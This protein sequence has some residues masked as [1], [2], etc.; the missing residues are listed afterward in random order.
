MATLLKNFKEQREAAAR[1]FNN[2]RLSKITFTTFRHWKA[3]ME[4]HETKDILWVMRFLGHSSLK[5]TLIYIDL[6]TA[7][8][9]DNDEGFITKV[10]TT[11]EEACGLLEVGFEHVCEMNGKTIFKKRK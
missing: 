4:Y 1:K 5:T 2:P 10:A 6:E 8:F 11:V 9:R 7:L 3:T